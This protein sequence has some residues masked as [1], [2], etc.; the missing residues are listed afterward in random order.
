MALRYAA[1]VDAR[2]I[3]ISI[4]DGEVRLGGSAHGAARRSAAI[5]LVR[6]VR[7]VRRIDATLL[8]H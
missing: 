1:S 2:D 4:V 7:G 3:A 6:H 5:E 8:L